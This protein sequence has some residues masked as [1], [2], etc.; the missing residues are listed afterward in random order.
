MRFPVTHFKC[1]GD[2]VL[3]SPAKETEIYNAIYTLMSMNV[4]I[5]KNDKTKH[6]Q[7]DIRFGLMVNGCIILLS[8]HLSL[9]RLVLSEKRAKSK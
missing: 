2:N 7:A 9:Y 8:H 1:P 5:K 3:M 6:K 4:C